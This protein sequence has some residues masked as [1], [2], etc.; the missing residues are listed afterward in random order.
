MDVA[1]RRGLA[2]MTSCPAD[3]TGYV[4]RERDSYTILC[5]Y[6]QQREHK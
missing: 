6:T 1:F 5:E 3:M 2:A 4:P